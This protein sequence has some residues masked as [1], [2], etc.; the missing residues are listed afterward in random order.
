MSKPNILTREIA[1]EFLKNN[2]SLDLDKFTDIEETA[3]EVLAQQRGGYLAL[4]GLKSLSDTAAKALKPLHC[5]LGLHGLT[6]LSNVAAQALAQHIHYIGLNGLKSL[7]D[8]AA[9]A[10]AQHKEKIDLEG[11]TVLSDSP[12]HIALAKNLV[13]HSRGY[14]NLPSLT[15]ISDS[16]AEVL[17]NFDGEKL[18]CGKD[19]FLGK[20]LRKARRKQVI[21]NIKASLFKTPDEWQNG[22]IVLSKPPAKPLK[23][24]G[25]ERYGFRGVNWWF[26]NNVCD[27][28]LQRL[29]KA[30]KTTISNLGACISREAFELLHSKSSDWIWLVEVE[31]SASKEQEATTKESVKKVAASAGLSREQL[32][33]KL[34]RLSEMVDQ[35][36][37]DLAA[38]M[39]AGFGGP[40]LYEALLAGAFISA[41]CELRPGKVL[42]RFKEYSQIIMLLAIANLPRN[43][44]VDKTLNRQA[45]ML[46]DVTEDNFE[47][48]AQLAARLP[49][50]RPKKIDFGWE[51]TMPNLSVEAASFL[52]CYQG[53]LNLLGLRSLSDEAAKSL[54]EHKGGLNLGGLK[55]LSDEAAK[56][57]AEHKGGLNL[58]GLKSLSDEAAKSL[59]E[60]EG[61]LD[62][63]GLRSISDQ[64]A[65]SLAKHEGGLGLGSIT[66]LSDAAALAL[67]RHVGDLYLGG[68]KELNITTARALAKHKGALVLAWERWPGT[69]EGLSKLNVEIMQALAEHKGDLNLAGLKKL[70]DASAEALARHEG[71][72][73]LRSITSL[74]DA[75]A[76][77][78]GNHKGHIVLAELKKL[79]SDG[80]SQ[81]TN[82]PSLTLRRS[83]LGSATLKIFKKAGTWRDGRSEMSSDGRF[84]HVYTWTRNP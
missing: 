63:G 64:A 19:N 79:S 50:L 80:A 55:S 59:A 36:N 1:E 13:L 82:L 4:H 43:A 70:N 6:S 40:W 51:F 27:W 48:T 49:A 75:S 62:L 71:E 78:L 32:E 58:G 72:L 23:G 25:A 65:K 77:A 84:T 76:Q 41:E 5:N 3:A 8:A 66:S 9:L 52:S 83:N 35:G 20:K 28:F 18:H 81:L 67:G 38:D 2:D 26:P 56:S 16:A 68:L 46:V 10:L 60:H 34:N 74:S 37:L 12:G 17:M 45:K 15:S 22:H 54:A 61:S 7:S 21:A 39:I 42:K 31:K 73:N 14:I 33:A 24:T 44:S 69:W 30:H 53:E 11:L 29:D 47:V 57:L